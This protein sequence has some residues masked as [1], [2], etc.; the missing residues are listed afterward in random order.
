MTASTIRCAGAV[1]YLLQNSAVEKLCE[2]IRE[3]HVGGA[4]MS[5][6]MAKRVRA[7]FHRQKRSDKLRADL[8]ERELEVLSVLTQ[9]PSDKVIA[10]ALHIRRPTV[11]LHY[12]NIYATLHVKS[13]AEAVI[14]ALQEEILSVN[15]EWGAGFRRGAEW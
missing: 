2:G 14:K 9:G 11:R 5:S 1:G 3:A 8:S 6:K 7:Y 15:K 4:P 10:D 12:K 13:H